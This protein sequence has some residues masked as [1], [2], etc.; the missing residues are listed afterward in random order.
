[1]GRIVT[2]GLDDSPGSTKN[3]LNMCLM[4]ILMLHGII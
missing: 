1:M 2:F 4:R 3:K